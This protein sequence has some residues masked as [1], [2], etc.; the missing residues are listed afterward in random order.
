VA[1]LTAE[2][3]EQLKTVPL[4]LHQ[5]LASCILSAL[6]CPLKDENGSMTLANRAA[7]YLWFKLGK[8][9]NSEDDARVYEPCVDRI[10]KLICDE[11]ETHLR[12]WWNAYWCWVCTKYPNVAVNHI[13]QFL[14]EIIDRKET[15]LAGLLTV[16]I[17]F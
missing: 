17:I 13:P 4:T 12:S 7:L 11:G 1:H 14:E 15:T 9:M 6:D 8:F 10:Y 16:S 5:Q 3:F 2:S